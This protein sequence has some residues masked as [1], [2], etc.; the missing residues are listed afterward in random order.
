[1]V[2]STSAELTA[3]ARARLAEL[4]TAALVDHSP[5]LPLRKWVWKFDTHCSGLDHDSAILSVCQ[6]ENGSSA[7]VM[8]QTIYAKHPNEEDR[9]CFITDEINKQLHSVRDTILAHKLDINDQ[10]PWT[11]NVE[12][13]EILER[14][15][16]VVHIVVRC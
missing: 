1:M 3:R 9:E 4:L 16:S 8:G 13:H 12:R 6:R 10:L 2:A 5:D 7:F 11:V 15:I 14:N